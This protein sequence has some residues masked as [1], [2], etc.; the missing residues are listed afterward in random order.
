MASKQADKHNKPR[1]GEPDNPP[2]SSRVNLAGSTPYKVEPDEKKKAGESPEV[3]V[4]VR[5]IEEGSWEVSG[6]GSANTRDF[7][8]RPDSEDSERW[9]MKPAG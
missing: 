1:K 2:V 9:A 5:T 4:V 8:L 6:C 3:G 7:I